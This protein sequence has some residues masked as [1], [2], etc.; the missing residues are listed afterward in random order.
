[1]SRPLVAAFML[2]VGV[3]LVAAQDQPVNLCPNPG[4]EEGQGDQPAGGWTVEAG[5]VTWADDQ[6]HSGQHAFKI[7]NTQA[8]QTVGWVSPMVPVPAG[9]GT[10][11]LSFWAKL[12]D[13]GGS[14]GAFGGFYHTDEQ[15]KRIGQSGG[16]FLGGQGDAKANLDWTQFTTVAN[17]TPE[18]KGLRVNMR[19]YGATGTAWFDDV[20]VSHYE[21]GP[22]EHAATVRRGLRLKPPGALAIVGAEGADK[23]TQ[24]ISEALVAVGCKAPVI[25][26]DQVDLSADAR[27]FIVLGNLKTSAA[28]MYLYRQSYAFEDLYYPGAGGYVLRPLTNPAGTGGNVLVVGASDAAGLQA[29]VAAL[30]PL[31]AKAQD[32]LDVPL[33]IKTG[34]TYKG[35]ASFPYFSDGPRA[36]LAPVGAYLKLGDTDGA[37]RF[38]DLM[39]AKAKTPDE[40]LFASDNSLHLTYQTMTQAWDLMWADPVF[41]DEERLAIDNFLLKVL[42]SPQGYDYSG[43]R[44]GMYSR[45]NHATRA[46]MGFYYGWRHFNKLYRPELSWELDLWRAR[47]QD[48]WAACFA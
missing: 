7:M 28:V 34:P 37:R 13:V 29:G 18:V 20:V 17:L 12:Q 3:G 8:G 4:A 39:L 32:V 43:L 45:E 14:N 38:R 26:A 15:G 33:T 5:N 6:A 35:L 1:M 22:L 16:I 25:A 23:E 30:L 36:E 19:L 48:F 10:L 41:S 47:L 42:R 46:A 44:A 21:Q 11:V 2:M 24:A 9:G 27:D 31:I 40:Q